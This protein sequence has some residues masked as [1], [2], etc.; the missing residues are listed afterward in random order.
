[1]EEIIFEVP[2]TCVVHVY[3]DSPDG[4]KALNEAKQKGAKLLGRFTYRLDKAHVPTGEEHIHVFI[5][6]K[7]VFAM[8]VSGSAHDRSHGTQLSK[9]VADAIREKVPGFTIPPNNFIEGRR[10]IVDEI[11]EFLAEGQDTAS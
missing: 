2:V 5:D 11:N 3:A 4:I 8:N 9:S 6:Q 1:V 10:D 7:Q